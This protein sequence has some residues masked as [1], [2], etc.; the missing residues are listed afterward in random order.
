M[1]TL[2]E[3]RH[4]INSPVLNQTD[5]HCQE[6][7][8]VSKLPKFLFLI[9]CLHPDI[10]EFRQLLNLIPLFNQLNLATNTNVSEI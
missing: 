3:Q 4:S 7:F 5:S 2:L 9:S 1:G 6:G 10:E 8:F